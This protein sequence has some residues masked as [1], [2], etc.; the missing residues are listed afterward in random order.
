MVVARYLVYKLQYQMNMDAMDNQTSQSAGLLELLNTAVVLLDSELKVVFLNPAAEAMFEIS[1]RQICG[2]EWPKVVQADPQWLARLQ[3]AAIS[4][5]A[6][7]ERELE[8]FDATGHPITVDCAVTSLDGGELLLEISPVDHLLRISKEEQML[9][10]QHSSRDLLRGLA[11]E[12]KNPLGGLRGAAQ[13]L[14]RELH[15][16][17]Q[18]EY[19]QVIIGEADRLRNLVDRM[20]GPNS[21]PNK[22]LVN[23][24]EVL[25][26]VRD[27]VDAEGYPNLVIS[28]E[29]DPSIPEINADKELLI[30]AILNLVR[31]AAQSG[32]K[33]IILQTRVERQLSIGPHRYKLAIRVDVIDNGPGIPDELRGRIFYPMVT[34][35][36]EGTGLGLSIAQSLVNQHDGVIE[37]DS[38]PGCTVFTIHLPL[39]NNHG[40]Y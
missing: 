3:A 30:Q 21:V 5:S 29:Y 2:L 28:R 39:E 26:R 37:C 10:L 36:A 19:T 27:L 33:A 35:R 23:V 31:N 9:S 22:Q 13:L 20:V 6:Q 38:K 8:I 18:K 17:E 16:E 40:V 11:H 14:E 12:I 1:K 24:H 4:G 32:G 25:E 15:S 7:L 34:G